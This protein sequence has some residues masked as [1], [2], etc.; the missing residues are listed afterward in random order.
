MFDIKPD[1]TPGATLR[2]LLLLLLMAVVMAFGIAARADSVRL[3]DQVGV[4]GPTVTLAHVAQLQGTSAQLHGNIVLATLE[5]G[6]AQYTVTLDAIEK[7]LDDAGVN[8]GRVSLRG[9]NTCL[10]TRITQPQIATPDQ[11]QAV[12]AN[13]ETPIGLQTAMTLRGVLEQHINDRAASQ[14]GDIRIDF[15][16]R[17]AKKL[18]IPILGRSIEIEPI[19]TNTLGKV[20]VVIRLYDA[21]RIAETIRVNAKV[22]HVL[23][24]VVADGPIARGEVFTR[25]RLKVQECYVD[26][27]AVTPI[28]DP[29]AIIGKESSISLRAG[30]MISIRKVKSPIMVKRGEHVEVRCFIGGLIVK[31]TGYAAENGSLDDLIRLRSDSTGEDYYAVVTGRHQ[32]VV[33]SSVTPMAPVVTTLANSQSQGVA[34]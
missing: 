1:N 14:L 4:E 5:D 13:I 20:P 11:G 25:S 26:D 28:T 32:A 24:A 2:R 19:S 34:P 7:A 27:N 31:T 23:L 18:D 3:Y 9:F 8:W 15:S 22:Q 17:D 21:Q 33:S 16:E 10:V 30:E 29:T 12:A 6:H